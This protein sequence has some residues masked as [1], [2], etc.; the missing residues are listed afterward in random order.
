MS[1]DAGAITSTL[2]L[3]VSEF[4]HGMLE[5]N[6]IA[7][8][9]PQT[10]TTFL[11][12]PLLGVMEVASRAAGFIKSAFLEVGHAA[13]N[14]GEAAEKAGVSVEFLTGVGAVAKDAGSSVEGL[15]D[16]LKFLNNNAADAAGGNAQTAANFAAIGVSATDAGGHLKTTEQL[17]YEVADAIAALPTPA[18]KTQAA[19]NLLGRGG[20]DMIATLNKGSGDIKGFAGQLAA[21]GGTVDSSLAAAGDKFGTLETIVDAAWEGIKKS[22]AQPILQYVADHFDEIVG[23]VTEVSGEIRGAIGS[24]MPTLVEMIPSVIELG[25]SVLSV[26]VPAFKALGDVL[27][28]VAKPLS[29]VLDLIAKLISGW[30]EINSFARQLIGLEAPPPPS[31]SSAAGGGRAGGTSVHV[32]SINVAGIDANAASSQIA[33]KLQGPMRDGIARQQRQV[34]AGVRADL[35]RRSL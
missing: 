5:A 19:M 16:A 11:A 1:F 13:D 15:A 8:V 25:E 26:V 23:K 21:L 31:S 7:S 27:S 12:N 29:F 17:F 30:G 20:V 6:A 14:A 3:D 22:I 18:Q 34:E 4:A 24:F 28:V 2:G 33:Q 35:V 9:F 32:D 10:V